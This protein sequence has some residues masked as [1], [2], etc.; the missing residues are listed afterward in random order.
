MSPRTIGPQD[1]VAILTGGGNCPGLND[2]I[3][4]AM[5][6]ARD[7][8]YK[9]LGVPN[10]YEGLLMPHE[11]KEIQAN[12]QELHRLPGSILGLSRVNPAPTDEGSEDL[13]KKNCRMIAEKIREHNIRFVIAIGGDDTLG[14]TGRLVKAGVVRA[15][16]VPKTIDNDIVGTERTFGFETAVQVG[17]E[18]ASGMRLEAEL[19]HRTCILETMGR[20]AGWIAL[21][22]GDRADADLILIR[23]FDVPVKDIIAKVNKALQEKGN[24]LIVVSE[25]FSIEGKITTDGT[26][27]PHG[28]KKLGGVGLALQNR[29]KEEGIASTCMAVSYAH[30]YGAPTK[31]DAAFARK[32]GQM[33]AEAALNEQFGVVSVYRAG[34]YTLAPF[35]EIKGGRLVPAD[36]YDPKLLKKRR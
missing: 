11:L 4:G 1:A 21:E 25:G 33:A 5:E 19:Y 24:A 28:N 12:S 13:F 2:A 8:G 26:I 7:A 16:G 32:L 31:E 10:G 30:R 15:N 17:K 35:T 34:E 18:H 36:L 3:L 20:L 27:D 6:R 22:V 14:A 23:E 9:V 29:L